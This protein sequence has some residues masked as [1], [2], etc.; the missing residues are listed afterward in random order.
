MYTL[1]MTI[2]ALNLF[3]MFPDEV[4]ARVYLESRI[5]SN[6]VTCPECGIIERT[7]TRKGKDGYYRCNAC[8][9]DFTVRTATIF[10]RSHVPLQKWLYAMYRLVTA[11]KGITSMQL[12]KEIGITLRSA[13]F[14]LHRLREACGNELETLRGN[15]EGEILDRATAVV[16]AYKPKSKTKAAKRRARRKKR[17]LGHSPRT[18]SRGL[19]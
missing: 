6:G 13:W 7:T 10:E 9:L 16:L 15:V 19:C 3:E 11:Q 5:W 2:S 18:E 17:S 1:D 14:V 12:G 8:K 4:A